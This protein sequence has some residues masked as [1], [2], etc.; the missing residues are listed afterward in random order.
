MLLQIEFTAKNQNNAIVYHYKVSEK[1]LTPN[2]PC[3]GGCGLHFIR[4]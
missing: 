3:Y 1:T 4:Q 2:P